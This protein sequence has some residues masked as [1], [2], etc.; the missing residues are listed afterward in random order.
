M[1][2][3]ADLRRP[4]QSQKTHMLTV[5]IKHKISSKK[6]DTILATGDVSILSLIFN[7]ESETES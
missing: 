2:V 1:A 5:G 6:P 7:H 4:R 3:R